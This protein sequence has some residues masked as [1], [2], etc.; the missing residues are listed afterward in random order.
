MCFGED[1]R[2]LVMLTGPEDPQLVFLDTTRMRVLYFMRKRLLMRK[3]RQW[4]RYNW[5]EEEQE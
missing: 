1:T 2:F 4:E 5:I 3:Y